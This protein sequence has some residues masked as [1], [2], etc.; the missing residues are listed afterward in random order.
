MLVTAG[1]DGVTP[2]LAQLFP[3]SAGRAVD[4]LDSRGP[5][6]TATAFEPQRQESSLA[7]QAQS[8]KGRR[9]RCQNIAKR[10]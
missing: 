7:R 10:R 2:A 4:I 3:D 5:M 1:V 8:R 6:K 9:F